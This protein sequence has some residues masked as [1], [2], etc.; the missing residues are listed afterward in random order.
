LWGYAAATWS[1]HKG[2]PYVT[3]ALMDEAP[4]ITFLWT[5]DPFFH[6]SFYPP[7]ISAWRW[8]AGGRRSALHALTRYSTHTAQFPS[9]SSS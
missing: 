8:N 7:L 3:R 6:I 9:S 4:G 2:E 5:K 1:S